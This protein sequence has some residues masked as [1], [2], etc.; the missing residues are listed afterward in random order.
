VR[1]GPR[2]DHRHFQYRMA[3]GSLPAPW[4]PGCAGRRP[5]A[6]LA[7]RRAAISQLLRARHSNPWNRLCTVALHNE[8]LPSA[9]SPHGDRDG[10]P[11]MER[12]RR[13]SLLPCHG[14]TPTGAAAVRLPIG[15]HA[16]GVTDHAGG[17]T[18]TPR[19]AG[20][21]TR[22][23]APSWRQY[24]RQRPRRCP[25]LRR[26]QHRSIFSG[27][28]PSTMRDMWTIIRP[29]LGT[30]VTT[31]MTRSPTRPQLGL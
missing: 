12:C 29:T 3:F 28:W 18:L 20:P 7:V 5:S 8:S 15:D 23:C 22:C 10:S 26:Y 30:I 2:L 27:H 17:L 6:T 4:F 11:G 25:G 21:C 1:A 9:P 31:T 14:V 13:W 19:P 24:H 16:H